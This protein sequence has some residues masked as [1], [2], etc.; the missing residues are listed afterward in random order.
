MWPGTLKRGKRGNKLG[1]E[2]LQEA[3]AV[4]VRRGREGI[5]EGDWGGAGVV[6]WM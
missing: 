3:D 6:R 1:Q 4:T 5:R 2:S